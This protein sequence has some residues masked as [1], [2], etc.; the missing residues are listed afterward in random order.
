VR[1]PGE[2]P[3]TVQN[4][5]AG[6]APHQIA[7]YLKDLAADFHSWYNA[8]RMLVEDE[9]LKLARLALAAAVRQVIR[10]G[11]ALLGVSAPESM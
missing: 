2:L 7:F 10:S 3:E 4:A 8:E 11:L 1:A 5:A 6:Y 9:A